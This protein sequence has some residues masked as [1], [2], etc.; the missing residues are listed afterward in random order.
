MRRVGRLAIVLA[1]ALVPAAGCGAGKRPYATD[2]L[3]RYGNA[4]WGNADRARGNDFRP[5]GEP[6]PPRAPHAPQPR[7]PEWDLAAEPAPPAR[8][9]AE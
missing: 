6:D 7:T 2:P 5:P 4:V 3:F 1:I 8:A 9:Q